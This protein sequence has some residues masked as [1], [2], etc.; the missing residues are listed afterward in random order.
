MLTTFN[1]EKVI[2]QSMQAPCKHRKSHKTLHLYIRTSSICKFIHINTQVQFF[3]LHIRQLCLA[4]QLN[5][6]EPATLVTYSSIY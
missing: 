5:L 6:K 1:T 3:S 4:W 2:N